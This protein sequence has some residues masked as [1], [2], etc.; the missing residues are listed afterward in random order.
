MLLA[1]LA[2]VLAPSRALADPQVDELKK[3]G[4][5]AMVDLNYAEAVDAY[6][7]AIALAP[8]DASLYYNVGRAHQARGDY[9]SALDALEK[10]ALKASP[11]IRARVPKYDQ[12]VGDVRGRVATIELRCSADVADASVVIADKTTINGC[13]VA[14]KAVRIS[15]A[16]HTSV[17]E[18]R[19]SAES[20]QSQTARVTVEGGGPIVPVALTVLPK[21]SSGTLLVRATPS[22][23]R[24]S[25]DG[26][27][28]GN[29][30]LEVP[31]AAGPHA[32]DVHADRYDSAHVPVVVEAG[33]TKDVG[34]EL[35]RQAPITSK[36]WFWTGI[37]VLAVGAG[38][39]TWYLIAQP[40]SDA[41]NGSIAPG[42]VSAPLRF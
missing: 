2:L 40:E 21:T 11:E 24:I 18:V 14:P 37:G 27:E 38:I 10:F 25:V 8:D 41:S 39:T 3:R 1:V 23:A 42:Q 4:N 20:V 6:T 12:L 13:T 22:N 32:V 30:P 16:A 28:R 34:V 36:W 35:R 17:I 9:P 33:R 29:S 19:L 31:L 15:V 7:A 5:D 26:I